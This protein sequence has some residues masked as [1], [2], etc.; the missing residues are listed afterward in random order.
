VLRS[1]RINK[2]IDWRGQL[3]RVLRRVH[4]L[5]A[6]FFTGLGALDYYWTAEQTEWATDVVFHDAAAL[7]GLYQALV[8]RGIDTFQSPDVLRFLG[9]KMP[10][11][12]GVRGSYQGEV[13]SD[14]KRRT[15]GVRIKHRAGRIR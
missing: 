14:L 11:H 12:G 9:H 10:A 4:P 1:W 7:S 13:R 2:R 3:D 5:H 8:R 6:K 15:E